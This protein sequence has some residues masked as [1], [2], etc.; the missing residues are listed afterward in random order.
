MVHCGWFLY[1]LMYFGMLVLAFVTISLGTVGYYSC[2]YFNQSMTNSSS[3]NRINDKYSQNVFSRIDVCI[4][5]NGKVLEK[6][7]I[8]NEMRTVTD[9]FT[10]ISQYF[11]YDN[12]L[13]TSYIDLNIS[14]NKISGWI[15]AMEKYRLG[16][17]VD[18][19]PQELTNDNPNEALKQLNLYSNT[20]GGV[21]TCSKDRWVFD[22][23]N[24]TDPNEITYYADATLAN[25][26]ALSSRVVTCISLNEKLTT[27]MNDSWSQ[28]DIAYRYL[29]IRQN[30]SYSFD[31]IAYYANTLI[32][33][34]NSR[35]NLFQ[36]IKDKLTELYN[37][38]TNFNNIMASFRLRVNQFQEAVGTLYYIISNEQTGLL[39][40]S[41]CRAV[42]NSSKAV[43]NIFCVNFMVQIVKVAICTLIML[44]TMLAAMC[45]GVIFGVRYSNVE[46]LK[47]IN[48]Q[49]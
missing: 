33:Y 16:V 49:H 10:N 26:Q 3:Y 35:V 20:G 28:S 15:N 19:R 39:A 8:N 25:G 12:P 48:A 31:R 34:R 27:S 18:S 47:R 22:S 1:T 11:D 24:C 38:N 44:V 14:T 40:T 9:V 43:Y 6:F 42:G 7:N 13:S 2:Q 37:L 29:Q 17:Y 45:L 46:M 32:N 5:G 36:S 30:C 4:L 21:P 23:Q 41:N